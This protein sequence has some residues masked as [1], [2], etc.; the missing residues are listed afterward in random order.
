MVS[1]AEPS[2]LAAFAI[3][4]DF[5]PL[6]AIAA[7]E[8]VLK[9]SD[10]V[11]IYCY[12]SVKLPLLSRPTLVKESFSGACVAAAMADLR[13]FYLFLIDCFLLALLGS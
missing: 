3:P 2:F 4:T 9:V 6:F 13:F 8:A 5:F 11:I 1:P 12:C 7:N 10:Y